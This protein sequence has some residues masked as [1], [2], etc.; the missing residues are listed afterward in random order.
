MKS[1]TVKGT[2]VLLLIGTTVFA[3]GGVGLE[4]GN[5]LEFDVWDFSRPALEGYQID[6]SGGGARALGMGRAFLGLSDDVTAISWNPA[7]LYTL[8]QPVISATYGSTLPRGYTD[9]DPQFVLDPSQTRFDHNGWISGI[10]ALDFA[11]PLRIKGHPFVGSFTYST[12]FDEYQG[13]QF[14]FDTTFRDTFTT[15]DT[16]FVDTV[17]HYTVNRESEMDGALKAVSFGFGTRIYREWSVGAALN[18]YSGTAVRH[19]ASYES[20]QD[21]IDYSF[22]EY[23][24]VYATTVID[25]NR[26]SGYNFTLGVRYNASPLAAGLIIRTPFDLE[27]ET[28]RSIYEI[29]KKNERV[30]AQETDT[31]YF[32]DMVTKY[33]MPWMIG[34]GVAY[35]AN[36]RTV[37]TADVEYRRFSTQG[38]LLRDSVKID[39]GGENEEFFTTVAADTLWK[40]VL[41][42]AVGAEYLWDQTWGTIPLRFGLAYV[43]TIVP[44]YER[45]ESDTA[46]AV[47]GLDS[48]SV[49]G[50]LVAKQERTNGV[51]L[52]AGAGIWWKQVHLD[53]AYSYL[54]RDWDTGVPGT[55]RTGAF[56]QRIR[57]HHVSATFTGY[58]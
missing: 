23:S 10:T 43:P 46:N 56:H 20:S 57:N 14:S 40:D 38:V 47:L 49:T 32:D 16:I 5:R 11:A 1:L 24:Q 29:A 51:R 15:P 22:Q 13:Y 21:R 18:V 3:Q 50:R 35:K 52:S 9:T 4:Y 12:G 30:A 6:F 7:G 53:F 37:L 45:D 19:A 17:V 42:V 26:F 31:F 41:Q 2:V 44:S 48:A 33:E 34:A 8:S 36:E 25:S 28:D 54:T 39:P 58:F 27:V 55:V